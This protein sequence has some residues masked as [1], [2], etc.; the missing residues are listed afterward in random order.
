MAD[1][2]LDLT[3]IVE[4]FHIR[5][6]GA[7][8]ILAHPDALTLA[9]TMRMDAIRPRMIELLNSFRSGELTPDQEIE[10]GQLLDRGCRVILDAPAVVHDRL[11]D[12]Q[13]ISILEAFITLRPRQNGQ[14]TGATEMALP[15]T[16]STSSPDSNAS[17]TALPTGG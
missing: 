9:Q 12:T 16:G 6:D 4:K 13:R 14:T 15:L 8:H 10:L 11:V 7:P 5:I 17:T 3:T 2:L 1:T